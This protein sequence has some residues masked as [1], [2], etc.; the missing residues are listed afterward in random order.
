[1]TPPFVTREWS[2]ASAEALRWRRLYLLVAAGYRSW[3]FKLLLDGREKL[4]SFGN[5]RNHSRSRASVRLEAR[6]ALEMGSD[7]ARLRKAER[8]ARQTRS[9][10]PGPRVAGDGRAH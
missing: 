4:L 6:R 1:M 9:K 5:S 3:R 2:E 7:R 10:P 8:A